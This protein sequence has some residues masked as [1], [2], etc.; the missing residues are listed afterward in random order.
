MR[1][2]NDEAIKAADTAEKRLALAANHNITD[3]E[4][5]VQEDVR[6]NVSRAAIN[7]ERQL[8]MDIADAEVNFID[9]VT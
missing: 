3:L 9:D 2:L 1:G 4:V 6:K 5:I 8:T 7:F